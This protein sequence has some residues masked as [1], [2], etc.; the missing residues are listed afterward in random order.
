MRMA[1]NRVIGIG[2][3]A[4]GLEGLLSF[5]S[6]LSVS[7][8]TAIIIAQH[9]ARDE[10]ARLVLNLLN[11]EGMWPAVIAEDYVT[12]SGGRVYLLP[13][14]KDGVVSGDKL[15]LVIPSD[16]SYSS[17]SVNRLLKSIAEQH[18]R[19]SLAIILS[20]AG[21]DGALGCRAIKQNGGQVW[22]QSPEDAAYSSMPQS[23]AD[24]VAADLSGS[25][26]LLAAELNL[27][28][29]VSP[30]DTG[31]LISKRFSSYSAPP[32]PSASP[33]PVPISENSSN[34]VSISKIPSANSYVESV[35]Q[36]GS[37]GAV[38]SPHRRIST[39]LEQITELIYQ[40]TGISFFGYKEET[41]DRRLEKRKRQLCEAQSISAPSDYME[42]LKCHHGELDILEQCL[43]VSVSSFY[44][45]VAVFRALMSSFA[46]LVQNKRERLISG[47]G[48][49]CVRILVAGC[50][51]GEEAYSLAILCR[52]LEVSIP[53][54]ITAIDLNRDAIRV[55]ERGVYG[56]KKLSEMP[57][58]L[59]S[60][61]F[62][63][64]GSEFSIKPA[65]KERVT[66]IQGDIFA[67]DFDPI[68]DFVSCRNLMIYLKREQQDQL[69]SHLHR[70]MKEKSGLVIGLTESLSPE[71]QKLFSTV[72]YYFRIYQRR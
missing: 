53:V 67:Q 44:R 26:L 48:D 21:S 13:A 45:D 51:T 23:A 5:F 29:G 7:T 49:P 63:P 60:R 52:Q 65:I 9:M 68:F 59:I 18:R 32:M 30:P 42:Y 43:L 34:F 69:I 70:Q 47:L 19:K 11:R 16:E 28:N 41:L 24:A 8:D 57:E 2:A 22:V 38:M 17:P 33:A 46:A 6:A 14:E 3:S 40:H 62:D 64:A 36:N 12:L 61:Y 15:R 37:P 39:E 20:G 27:I 71:G 35:L 50:A 54:E 25:V 56:S 55:A 4:G 72:D 58:E 31:V 10:H 66:F 1:L